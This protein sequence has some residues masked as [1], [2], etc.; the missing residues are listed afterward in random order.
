MVIVSLSEF[1]Y[2][3]KDRPGTAALFVTIWVSEFSRPPKSG[4]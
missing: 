4:L 3:N 1:E 2:T